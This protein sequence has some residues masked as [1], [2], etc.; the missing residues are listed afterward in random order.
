MDRDDFPGRHREIRPQDREFTMYKLPPDLD[1]DYRE[2]TFVAG[3]H[4]EV[5]GKIWVNDAGTYTILRLDLNTGK[6]EV[7]EPFP[8]PR[9]NIYEITSD[10]QNN[11]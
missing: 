2:L 11:A 10:A 4:N 9:P 5:D 8:Q 6:L 7:F 1:G 3:N